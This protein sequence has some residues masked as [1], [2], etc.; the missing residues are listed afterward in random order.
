MW[1]WGDRMRGRWTR[2]ESGIQKKEK[3]KQI[4]TENFQQ[5]QQ[6][7]LNKQIIEF[8]CVVAGQRMKN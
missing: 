3:R 1:G 8:S 5:R 6:F 4:E 7:F 2:N